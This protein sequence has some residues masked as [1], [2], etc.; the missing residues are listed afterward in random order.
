MVM[1]AWLDEVPQKAYILIC[2]HSCFTFPKAII[3]MGVVI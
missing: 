2:K 3:F 1:K